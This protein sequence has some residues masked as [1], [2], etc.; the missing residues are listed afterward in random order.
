[1]EGIKA[2]PYKDEY[3]IS[4]VLTGGEVF[5]YVHDQ[6]HEERNRRVAYHASS[7]VLSAVRG[8][9]V[10]ASILKGKGADPEKRS[11]PTNDFDLWDGYG[12][13][14]SGYVREGLIS[15]EL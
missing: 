13:C 4:S 12:Y 10:I 7:W 5:S 8:D 1:M 14:T 15:F 6:A 11:D 9:G 3:T 2:E